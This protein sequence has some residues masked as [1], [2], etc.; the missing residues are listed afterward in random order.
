MVYSNLKELS[1]DDFL[2][3]AGDPGDTFWFLLRG[4][5]DILSKTG[6]EF[7]YS[8]GIDES[9]FYGKKEFYNENR[10]DYAKV[11]S[12]KALL[13]E[14]KTAKFNS[15]VNK[16]QI[17]EAQ[18]KIDFL[19]RYVPGFRELP[20]RMIED[21]EVFFLKEQVTQGFQIQ[22]FDENGDYIYFIY[23][24]LCKLLYPTSKMPDIFIKSDLYDPVKQKYLMFG[25]LKSGDIFGE[26]C[27]L[28][29]ILSSYSVVACSN[30]VEYYKIHRSH[31]L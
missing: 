3:Q 20:K 26:Q 11:T 10:L 5:L 6:D 4:K 8:K 13:I 25:H 27:A 15:V 24:G 28:N 30:K 21:F 9:T 18:K 22:K 23:R 12:E 16:T 31:F 14:F 17:S 19:I 1:K 2:Y 29:D 7:K